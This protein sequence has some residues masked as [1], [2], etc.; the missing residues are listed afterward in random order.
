QAQP[1]YAQI[2]SLAL[3]VS[4]S[5]QLAG[6]LRVDGG[7]EVR[8]IERKHIGGESEAGDSCIRDGPLRLLQLLVAHLLRDAMEGL[9]RERRAG[10]A[11]Q[12]RQ[13]RIEKLPQFAL[14]SRCTGALDRHGHRQLAHRWAAF[15]ANPAAGPIDL[16]NQVQLFG[17]PDQRPDVTHAARAHRLG[18]TQIRDSR[19]IGR[20]QHDL[21]CNAAA[22]LR[23]PHGLR[24]DAVA[25]AVDYSFEDVHVL[26]CSI[27]KPKNQA[28]FNIH[29]LS[30][31]HS[32]SAPPQNDV[33]LAKGGL[34]SGY[35]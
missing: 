13:T 6:R 5:S 18:R 29:G 27:F 11:R 16:P 12:P 25:M 24:R 17:D 20:S 31:R 23:I 9:A 26:S 4:P 8:R 14:G 33:E 10:Q 22:A 34:W 2:P 19:W 28:K 32:A 15:G 7:I 30:K 1:D 21:A 35:D 3:G